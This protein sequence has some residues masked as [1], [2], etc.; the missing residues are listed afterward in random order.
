MGKGDIAEVLGLAKTKAT[1]NQIAMLL[2]FFAMSG[3]QASDCCETKIVGGIIYKLNYIAEEKFGNC[4]DTCI[5][6]KEEDNGTTFCF[7]P[8]DELPFCRDPSTAGP[9]TTSTTSTP[10][11][12]LF[13]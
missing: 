6:T 12:A 4:Y 3:C 1:T 13:A 7:G 11:G 5:Y 10:P 2:L 9:T 8:G